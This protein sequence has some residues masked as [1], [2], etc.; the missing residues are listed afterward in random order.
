MNKEETLNFVRLLD[1]SERLI[2]NYENQDISQQ[3]KFKKQ[4]E[5]MQPTFAEKITVH[6]FNL[7]RKV[8]EV[9]I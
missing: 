3:Q 1:A 8:R 2:S 4:N 6:V 9:S 5:I 7:Q